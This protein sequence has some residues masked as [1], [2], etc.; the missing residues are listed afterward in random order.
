MTQQEP[1]GPET[2]AY[3]YSHKLPTTQTARS[4]IMVLGHGKL[5]LV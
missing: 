1:K 5:A 3:L 2:K 4:I